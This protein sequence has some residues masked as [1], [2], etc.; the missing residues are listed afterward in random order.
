MAKSPQSLKIGFTGTQE[1]MKVRQIRTVG[2]AIL[3]HCLVEYL[4]IEFHHGD[5]IGAD[6][7]VH[8]LARALWFKVHVHPH[9]DK[10]RRAYCKTSRP[11]YLHVPKPYL[12]RNK[13]IVDAT[14]VLIAAPRADEEVRS[15]TWATVRY[16]RKL[17]RP[18]YIC[19]PDGRMVF[20]NVPTQR[21]LYAKKQSPPVKPALVASLEEEPVLYCELCGML[22][23]DTPSGITCQHGHGGAGSVA[24]PVT[25]TR[26]RAVWRGKQEE[27]KVQRWRPPSRDTG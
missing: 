1:G 22:Q 3:C 8:Y 15:G 17:N 13:D 26:I 21:D 27:G 25:A 19:F 18:I 7:Q 6:E 14:T 2:Q 24:D 23:F 11:E 20:E 10:S 9:D 5:C 4:P 12:M 16:A